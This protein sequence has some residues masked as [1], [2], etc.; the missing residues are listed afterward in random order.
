MI[1]KVQARSFHPRPK[2]D[3]AIVRFNVLPEPAVRVDDID[4]FFD[5]V[6]RGFSSPRKQLRNSLANG[7]GVKPAEIDELWEQAKISPQRRAETLSLEEWANL[8]RAAVVLG[9]DKGRC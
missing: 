1:A 5:V 7:Y 8:Y 2:V 6:R 4:G 9:K 3:S